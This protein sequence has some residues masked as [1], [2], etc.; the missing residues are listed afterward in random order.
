MARRKKETEAPEE[1]GFLE[2]IKDDVREAIE[3]FDL[4]E[5]IE[6]VKDRVLEEI[7]EAIVAKIRNEGTR[8]WVECLVDG[9]LR[10]VQTSNPDLFEK[11]TGVEPG[12]RVHVSFEK[13][14]TH[15]ELQDL[16]VL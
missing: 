12:Q 7:E 13:L 1:T 8:V 14:D 16:T 5:K 15:E 10:R 9:A 3:D 2:E 4:G 6:A 11:L